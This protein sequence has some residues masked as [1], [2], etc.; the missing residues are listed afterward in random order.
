MFNGTTELTQQNPEYRQSNKRN[1]PDFS[2]DKLHWR[3]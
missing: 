2:T 1:D 3:K